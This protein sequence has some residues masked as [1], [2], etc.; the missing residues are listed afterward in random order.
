MSARLF[1]ISGIL[2]MLLAV[3]LGAFGA[4]GLQSIVTEHA[5]QTWK[6]AVQYQVY[7]ALGLIGLGTWSEA[8]TMSRWI[9]MTALAFLTGIL[10]FCVSLYALVLSGQ[11]LLGM[12]TPFGGFAFLIG[13]LCWLMAVLKN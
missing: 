4:H 10:L 5:L 2:L 8:K 11:S 9:R 1:L 3:A 12:I 13:W 7:H 6:T